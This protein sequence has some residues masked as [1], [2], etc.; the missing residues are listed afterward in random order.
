MIQHVLLISQRRS[1]HPEAFLGK[2]FWKYA[3]NLQENIHEEVCFN[4]FAKQLYWDRTSA[5]TFSCKF[6]PYFQNTFSEEHLCRRIPK[7]QGFIS[8]K[9]SNQFPENKF[10]YLES[11]SIKFGF[12]ITKIPK[13]ELPNNWRHY[14]RKCH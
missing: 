14:F 3:V 11:L 6:A 9:L 5:W 4:K 7:I 1:S 10:Q 13:T 8:R 2:V 12:L